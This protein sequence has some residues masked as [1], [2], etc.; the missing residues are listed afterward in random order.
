M[1]LVTIGDALSED[2]L[3]DW[4]CGGTLMLWGLFCTAIFWYYYIYR[5]ICAV[6]ALSIYHLSTALIVYFVVFLSCEWVVVLTQ[7]KTKPGL[8]WGNKLLHVRLRQRRPCMHL[9]CMNETMGGPWVARAQLAAAH[10][11][12]E[13]LL[14]V[15][16]FNISAFF[17]KKKNC[18]SYLKCIYCVCIYGSRKHNKPCNSRLIQP[19]FLVRL[20]HSLLEHCMHILDT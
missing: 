16:P 17:F 15:W 20:I 12:K 18:A 1:A 7:L 19:L 2:C 4:N 10:G 3:K 11:F 9:S 6:L 13:K 14:R 8:T 5:L